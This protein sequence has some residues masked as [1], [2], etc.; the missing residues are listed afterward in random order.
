[1]LITNRYSSNTT[2]NVSLNKV[3][4]AKFYKNIR[5]RDFVSRERVLVPRKRVLVPIER[6]LVLR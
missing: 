5:E 1:M 3:S 6:V 4:S 2:Y